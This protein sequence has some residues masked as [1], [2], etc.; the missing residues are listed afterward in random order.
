MG[1][2]EVCKGHFDATQTHLPSPCIEV[3]NHT[4]VNWDC[5]VLCFGQE[6]TSRKNNEAEQKWKSDSGRDLHDYVFN[7]LVRFMILL[8]FIGQGQKVK[9]KTLKSDKDKPI[10]ISLKSKN[11]LREYY[12]LNTWHLSN[13]DHMYLECVWSL[14]EV[15][16]KAE[17]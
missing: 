6:I 4:H 9:R 16:D 2:I 8:S 15:Q 3:K 1:G 14:F 7:Y 17:F 13:C 10:I 12:L 11:Q 5:R